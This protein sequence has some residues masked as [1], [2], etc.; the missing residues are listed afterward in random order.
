MSESGTE[1]ALRQP[2]DKAAF[3]QWLDRHAP[4]IGGAEVQ[5]KRLSGGS[6]FGVFEVSRGAGHAVLRM[7]SWPPRP[8]ALKAMGRE[9]KILRAL[10]QTD[11]PH[12][13]LLGYEPDETAVGVSVTLLEFV[14]GWLGSSTPPPAFNQPGQRREGLAFALIDA[15]ARLGKVD[16]KAVGLEDLG[17][18]EGFLDRQVDRWQSHFEN[19]KKT[20]DHPGRELPGRNY[21]ADWLR[22]NK[23]EMQKVSLVHLDCSFPNVMFANE[24]PARVKAIIDWEIATIGDPL[25]DL[26]RAVYAL[27]GRRV[28][29]GK[30]S[31]SDNSDM[32][33]R[34]DLAERYAELTGLDVSH[35]DY[36][37]VL[38]AFKLAIIIEF[39]YYRVA[40]GIDSSEVARQVSD[41]IPEIMAFA[42][43][44][45]RSAG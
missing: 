43:S 40:L 20:Y 14:D 17:R 25:L 11:V 26:G 39:N 9:A 35:L 45:A 33:T 24:P 2:L 38:A 27:P 1:T 5:L 4:Q 32:P 36:Y 37:C 16:Y 31:M 8:D 6:S 22:A 29:A 10:G 18:P 15:I 41:Y 12:P 19:Y 30:N 3:S 7:P 28:G 13:R 44:V 23:P 34:E 42:E 21:V